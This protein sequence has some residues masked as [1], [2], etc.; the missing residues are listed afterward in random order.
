MAC[1]VR[2]VEMF[3]E[4]RSSRFSMLRSESETLLGLTVCVRPEE[5]SLESSRLDG[6]R[7]SFITRP[8]TRGEIDTL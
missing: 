4:L 5:D 7:E 2:E 6:K 3:G 8:L 1:S